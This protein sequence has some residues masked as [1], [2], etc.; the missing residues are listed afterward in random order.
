MWIYIAYIFITFIAYCV[1]TGG[2]RVHKL[3]SGQVFQ[4]NRIVFTLFAGILLW[5]IF[6]LRDI[7]VGSDTINYYERY[8]KI[9]K[10]EFS[11]IS[12]AG[13]EWGYDMLQYLCWSIGM[14]WQVYLAV[15]SAIIIAPMSLFFH[16]YSTNV[17]AS[18]F[19][20]ATIG[21]IGVNMS[22]T[23][24]SLAVAMI[25]VSIIA[26]FENKYITFFI[27]I[28]LGSLFHYSALFALLLLFVPKYK[29][30]SKVQLTLLLLV[31]LIARVTGELFLAPVESMLPIRYMDYLSE[32]L[33]MTPLLEAV[34]I[35]IMLFV[36]F[37]LLINGKVNSVEF[38]L[39]F[40]TVLFVTCNELSHSIYMAS[41]LSF[42]F[43]TFVMVAIPAAIVKFPDKGARAFLSIGIYALCLAFLIVSS[44]GSDTMA[45][46][47][48]KF[49]WE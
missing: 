2:S 41:R 7:S 35:S 36:Y 29:Y 19:L 22:A 9:E 13:Q 49:F 37:S 21:L 6:S 45:I 16:K 18:F 34:W 15:V 46:F 25:I 40:L 42:Y 1:F 14:S 23:R 17:W 39:Y 47:N 10:P 44:L 8:T 24:Q 4:K 26:M 20:Y 38:R 3:S 28:I 30:R 11:L 48:Y 43:E 27:F 5:L 32:D 33:E 31:P 12:F